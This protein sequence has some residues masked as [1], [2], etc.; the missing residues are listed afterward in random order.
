MTISEIPRVLE[1]SDR[2]RVI[3]EVETHLEAARPDVRETWQ[4]LLSLDMS[5][6]TALQTCEVGPA[7]RASG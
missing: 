4:Q 7:A 6:A 1:I 5:R 3:E 2:E